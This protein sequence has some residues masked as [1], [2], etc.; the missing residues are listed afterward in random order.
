LEASRNINHR[1]GFKET[2]GMS[3]KIRHLALYTENQDLNGDLLPK[4]IRNKKPP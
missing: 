4:G 1:A 2:V 3:A